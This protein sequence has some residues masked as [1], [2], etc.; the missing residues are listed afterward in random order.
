VRRWPSAYAPFGGSGPVARRL[1]SRVFNLVIRVLLGLPY[2]DTQ[3]GL[4]GFRRT[5]AREIFRRARLDGFAFDVEAPWLADR[6]GLE[7]VEVGV[8]ATERL[9][10]KVRVLADALRMLGEVWAV[11]Q[12]TAHGA[13]GDVRQDLT[14]IPDSVMPPALQSG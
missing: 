2:G 9:G 1:A 3:G 13:Y 4:K 11:R 14:R 12:A 8:R 6:L 5:A 10:S 7:V